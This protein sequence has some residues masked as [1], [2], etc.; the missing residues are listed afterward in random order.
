MGFR[1]SISGQE[2]ARQVERILASPEFRNS[3]TLKRFL[4]FVTEQEVAGREEQIK[5]STIAVEVFRRNP[6]F[7]PR[8]DNVVRVHAHRLRGK[9]KEYYQSAGAQ[10]PIRIEIPT[11][12]YHPRFSRSSPSS[13]A[14]HPAEA[15]T[16]GAEHVSGPAP[17]PAGWNIPLRMAV[18]LAAIS[19][20][21]FVAGWLMGSRRSSGS[22]DPDPL[23]ARAAELEGTN[24]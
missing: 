1:T 24:A 16:A 9:L 8:A 15:E 23:S 4:R 7:D 14:P 13:A 6:D 21:I 22:P 2:I 19:V 20:L 18:Y 10:D 3:E 5:E 11:G 12:H 17:V